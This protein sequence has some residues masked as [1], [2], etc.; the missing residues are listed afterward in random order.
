MDENGGMVMIDLGLERG[1]PPTYTSPTRP[2]TPRWLPAALLAVLVL[3]MTAASVAPAKSPLSSVFRL[4]VGPADT[5]AMTTD[6]QLLAQTFGLLTSYNLSDGR[7]R[8]QA[9]QSTPA[10]RLRLSD[11]LVLMKPWTIGSTEPGTT[12]VS[13]FSGASQWQRDG[14]VVPIAGSATLLAVTSVRSLTGTGRRVQGPIEAVDPTTGHTMW[15]VQVPSTAVLLGVPGVGDDES[16]MLL[17]HDDQTMA[18]HELDTGK[19]LASTKV[20]AADYNPQ[21]PVVAGGRI[22]LR[23]PGSVSPEISAYDAVTLKQL[24]TEPSGTSYQ[25]AACGL[26][27]CLS[28]AD[29]VRAID[30]DT[31]DTVWQRH[32]W[33]GLTQYGDLYVAFGDPDGA[34]P[35]GMVDPQTGALQVRLDGWRP[36]TGTGSDGRLLVTRAY[37]DGSRTMVAVAQPGD[38]RPRL[39]DALPVGTGECQAAPAR[40]V[41]RTMYSELV[42]WAYQE[43]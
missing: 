14:D 20:P 25:I 10:Y 11:D 5:Y 2:T 29:G 30:P 43:G 32:G 4:Q 9:G 27:A 7:L 16:R 22:L 39:L 1:E 26:L 13:M 21:N 18:I 28:G 36:V 6:G 24:W 35:L 3:L 31:G 33:R 40:L 34:D 17:V 42:V 19:L 41:C 8:W 15:T 37:D 38:P 23:H 12:A